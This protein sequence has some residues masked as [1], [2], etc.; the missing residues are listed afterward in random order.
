MFPVKS[1]LIIILNIFKYP[2]GIKAFKLAGIA[3]DYR[4]GNK[5]NKMLPEFMAQHL[6]AKKLPVSL[7]FRQK[8]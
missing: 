6:K 1:Y 7:S 5:H 2:N 4:R 3:G 8:D